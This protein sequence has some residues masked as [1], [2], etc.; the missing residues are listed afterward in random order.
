MREKDKA[1]TLEFEYLGEEKINNAPRSLRPRG[2]FSF[3]GHRLSSLYRNLNLITDWLN[4]CYVP[5]FSLSKYSAGVRG[6]KT[7]AAAF[8]RSTT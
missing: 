8:Q 3:D 2:D 4:N 5:S 1:D 6:C 7:P